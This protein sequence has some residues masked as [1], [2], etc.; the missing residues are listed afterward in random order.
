[1][2]PA[3]SGTSKRTLVAFGT[4]PRGLMVPMAFDDKE[5]T[6]SRKQEEGVKPVTRHHTQ[7][8]CQELVGWTRDG[9][10]ESVSHDQICRV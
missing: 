9:A 4:Q 7:P 1:M 5:A 3:T 8:R 2:T 6:L 10:A